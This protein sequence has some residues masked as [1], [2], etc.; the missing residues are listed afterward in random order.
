MISTN[1]SLP[2]FSS[3]GGGDSGPLGP[4]NLTRQKVKGEVNTGGALTPGNK[5]VQL[6]PHLLGEGEQTLQLPKEQRQHLRCWD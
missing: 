3:R 2:Q 5:T 6:R 1:Y 4:E